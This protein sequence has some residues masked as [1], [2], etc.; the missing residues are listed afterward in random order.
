MFIMT[1]V[2]VPYHGIL[3]GD[4]LVKVY[5]VPGAF[6]DFCQEQANS[7][8]FGDKIVAPYC[9]IKERSRPRATS[10]FL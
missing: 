3:F 4:V 8:L 5:N 6:R 7:S 2:E 10:L 1:I 9:R